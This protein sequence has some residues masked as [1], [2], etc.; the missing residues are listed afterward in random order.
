MVTKWSPVMYSIFVPQL[1]LFHFTFLSKCA[2]QKERKQIQQQQ[3][4]IFPRSLV[5]YSLSTRANFSTTPK[6]F[7]SIWALHFI[8]Y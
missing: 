7:H 3:N 6:C 8:Y 4:L 5:T 1:F 2:L